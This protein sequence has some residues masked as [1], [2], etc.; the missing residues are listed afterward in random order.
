MFPLIKRFYSFLPSDFLV[1]LPFFP[2]GLPLSRM[3]LHTPAPTAIRHITPAKIFKAIS[4]S[5]DKAHGI[6]HTLIPYAFDSHVM[7]TLE[8]LRCAFSRPCY[9]HNP[10]GALLNY[11][12]HIVCFPGPDR[13]HFPKKY[14]TNNK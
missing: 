7:C 10:S 12:L 13:I 14:A 4:A 11:Y 3:K 8:I 2:C 5:P 9:E 6:Q 1:L